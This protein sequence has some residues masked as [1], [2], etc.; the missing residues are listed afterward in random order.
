MISITARVASLIKRFNEIEGENKDK[1][2][3]NIPNVILADTCLLNSS[4]FNKD[5]SEFIMHFWASWCKPFLSELNLIQK[6][7]SRFPNKV[8]ISSS[9]LDTLAD[10]I[11]K[12][13][14]IEEQLYLDDSLFKLLPLLPFNLVRTNLKITQYPGTLSDYDVTSIVNELR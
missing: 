3:L 14:M 5:T 11:G 4:L 1:S 10:S 13:H 8:I 6:M 12:E 2:Y 7:Y 9:K